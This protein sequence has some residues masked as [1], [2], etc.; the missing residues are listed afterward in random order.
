MSLHTVIICSKTFPP[1]PLFSARIVLYEFT[2]MVTEIQEHEPVM[3]FN[4]KIYVYENYYALMQRD[5][6][7]Q[8]SNGIS[9]QEGNC[10]CYNELSILKQWNNSQV[11]L[12]IW[13]YSGIV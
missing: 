7:E 9:L 5:R 11:T 4:L 6:K 13:F 3:T 1:D 10:V 8:A 2:K 12:N